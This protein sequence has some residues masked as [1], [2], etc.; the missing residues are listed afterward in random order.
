MRGSAGKG[1]WESATADSVDIMTRAKET[2]R[3]LIRAMKDIANQLKQKKAF[4]YGIILLESMEDSNRQVN[5][6]SQSA[7]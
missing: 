5:Y 3:S 6:V 4:E 1:N 2:G 7:D